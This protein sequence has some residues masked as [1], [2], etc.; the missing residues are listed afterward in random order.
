MIPANHKWFRN[1]A[2]SH[3][4]TRTIEDMGLQLPP[5]QVDLADIRRRYHDAEAEAEQRDGKSGK[6]GNSRRHA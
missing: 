6:R 5:T 4:V 3:I 1:L 2:I